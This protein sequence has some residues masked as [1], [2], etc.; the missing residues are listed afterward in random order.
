MNP[1]EEKINNPDSEEKN[2][3]DIQKNEEDLSGS[4]EE[5]INE[6]PPEE[7]HINPALIDEYDQEQKTTQ[8]PHK[9]IY[10]LRTDRIFFG[11]CSGLGAYFDT[12]PL[13]FRLAFIISLIF[14]FWGIIFYLILAIVIPEEPAGEIPHEKEPA[15]EKENHKILIGSSLI[16][17]GIFLTVKNTRLFQFFQVWSLAAKYFVPV[18]LIIMGFYLLFRKKPLD[19]QTNKKLFRSVEHRKIAGV[20][21]GLGEYLNIDPTIIRILWLIFVFTSFGIAIIIYLLFSVVVPEKQE[22]LDEN[23]SEYN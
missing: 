7:I 11:V 16:L 13:F 4:P 14:G 19:I 8:E 1:D 23:K 10:R 20:C 3:S 15:L 2:D 9:N 22:E 6:N 12:E 17:L 18:S 5:Q 21:A